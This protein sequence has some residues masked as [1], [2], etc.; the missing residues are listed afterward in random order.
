MT[1]VKAKLELEKLESGDQLDVLVTEGE[2][3][4]NIPKSAKEQGFNVT[5]VSHVEGPVYRISIVKEEP[6]KP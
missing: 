5:E 6:V 3:L 2:P 1:F 4:E